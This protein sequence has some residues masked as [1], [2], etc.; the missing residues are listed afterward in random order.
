[1]LGVSPPSGGQRLAT[2]GGEK[3]DKRQGFSV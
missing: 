1:M 2:A 3:V